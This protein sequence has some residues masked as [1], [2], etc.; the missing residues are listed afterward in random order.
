MA[1]APDTYC[2]THEEGPQ[3]P[4]SRSLA[5][6]FVS[7]RAT[8]ELLSATGFSLDV[9]TVSLW[10]WHRQAEISSAWAACLLPLI[11]SA[12]RAGDTERATAAISH[13]LDVCLA[14]QL[15]SLHW[16]ELRHGIEEVAL[17]CG[18]DA[19]ELVT[20][21]L[22]ETMSEPL[23]HSHLDWR[24]SRSQAAAVNFIVGRCEACFVGRERLGGTERR[25]ANRPPVLLPNHA[26]S[27]C[28]GNALSVLTLDHRVRVLSD[29]IGRWEDDNAEIVVTAVRA[30]KHLLREELEGIARG[31]RRSERITQVARR[32]IHL[33]L[34][35][36]QSGISAALC[37]KDLATIAARAL[38]AVHEAADDSQNGAEAYRSLLYT[39]LHALPEQR[40][41]TEADAVFPATESS[42]S[43]SS[44]CRC[45]KADEA[46]AAELPRGTFFP[47]VWGDNRTELGS[48][49]ARFVAEII[50]EDEYHGHRLTGDASDM[51]A[52][53]VET[54]QRSEVEKEV[55]WQVKTTTSFEEEKQFAIR[56]R[57]DNVVAAFQTAMDEI[58]LNERRVLDASEDSESVSEALRSCLATTR[59]L[60]MLFREE[61]PLPE[62]LLCL[63]ASRTNASVLE[64]RIRRL[65]AII[66]GE[67]EDVATQIIYGET[68][69]GEEER[70]LVAGWMLDRFMIR[71]LAERNIAIKRVFS[72]APVM[73]LI[74]GPY[75]V[76]GILLHLGGKQASGLEAPWYCGIPFLVALGI[77][78]FFL[79]Q[80]YRSPLP[81]AGE[82]RAHP[83][84]CR[85][86]LGRSSWASCSPLDRM[87]SGA[88]AS[89]PIR[90]FEP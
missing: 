81:R 25:G 73:A 54:R 23:R 10:R 3:D 29:T 17:S 79:W 37:N 67:E 45:R 15:S 39:V 43:V 2:L 24:R 32:H 48:R 4:A 41:I 36:W 33:I 38:Y 70:R 53:M 12:H 49:H 1:P 8:V 62:R 9:L 75:V 63:A 89:S 74:L 16:D 30:L 84:S 34:P 72:R 58:V 61:L 31:T 11:S 77:A 18:V 40:F 51:L 27:W 28:Q 26:R 44:P 66:D 5:P 90:F 52:W 85:R 46:A 56:G 69:G 19:R 55:A 60:E 76:A 35:F 68:S 59:H 21:A 42:R 86:W 87:S 50:R 22:A 6:I 83:C 65:S 13:L 64:A 57:T 78:G 47:S 88:P 14:P 71:E 20:N 80:A 82:S 7:L